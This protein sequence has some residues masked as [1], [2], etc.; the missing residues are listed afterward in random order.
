[1]FERNQYNSEVIINPPAMPVPLTSLVGREHAIGAVI[2]LLLRPE[3]RLVSLTGIGGV[4]KTRLAL[5]VATDISQ[6]FAHGVYF[7]PLAANRDPQT[8]LWEIAHS[9]GLYPNG[10]SSSVL[11]SLKTA[12]KAK[13]LLLVLDNLEQAGTT[14]PLLTELLTTCPELKI[15]ATSQAVLHLSGEYHFPVNPLAYPD[16]AK[17]P[18]LD[19]LRD[20]YPAIE[21]FLQRAEAITPLSMH[22]SEN[23]E[24]VARI[25]AALEGLPLAIE[26]AAARVKFLPPVALLS[27]LTNEPRLK[28]LT[29]G[30]Q[31]RP[32]RQQSLRATFEWSYALLSEDEQRI[33]RR[34]AVLARGCSLEA[35]ETVCLNSG[36]GETEEVNTPFLEVIASLIDKSLL[37]P[38]DLANQTPGVRLLETV[39]EF[40]LEKLSAA[41]ELENLQ[42]AHAAYYLALAEEAEPELHNFRQ[43][44]WRRQ[45]AQNEP[46]LEAALDYLLTAQDWEGL[47]R[48]AGALGW[49]WY[50]GGRLSE[51]LTFLKQA[52][53]QTASNAASHPAATARAL[54]AA[55][56]FALHLGRGEQAEAWLLQSLKLSK[57]LRDCQGVA[58]AAYALTLFHLI[59][60]SIAAAQAQ[61]ADLLSFVQ[62]SGDSWVQ[63]LAQ[64]TSGTIQ[65]YLGDFASAQIAY[66]LSAELYTEAGDLDLREL[67]LLL[68]CDATLAQQAEVQGQAGTSLENQLGKTANKNLSWSVGYLLLGYG[69]IA[70]R[71]GDWSRARFLLEQSLT[72]FEG[73][74]DQRGTAQVHGV[75]ARLALYRQDY[76]S[77]CAIAAECLQKA[78]N[79]DS[80]ETIIVC[81]EKLAD[82]A[83]EHN[84]LKWAVQLW[85]AG[86]RQR[87]LLDERQ[88]P[89][90]PAERKRLVEQAR[91]GLGAKAFEEEWISGYALTPE[92]ALNSHQNDNQSV[93]KN[94]TASSA[95]SSARKTRPA[96]LTRREF[97]VLQLLAE[98]LSNAEIAR[99]LVLTP[100][101]V[102]SYLNNVY[103]KLGVSS[104][105]AAMRYAIDHQLC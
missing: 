46:N 45:L 25:C 38:L 100:A 24:A 101:T 6:N 80:R 55:G 15:L 34:L 26:L 30:G 58:K 32:L 68:Q 8:V 28:V 20:N 62:T 12:L 61:V 82:I 98:G 89:V 47:L 11:D 74:G 2:A 44:W 52:L 54:F 93:L 19:T 16:P 18:P 4:G 40:A 1:M 23:I 105:T 29:Q 92:R 33:F 57:S 64:T 79:V 97:D 21:L 49:F 70:L 71:R 104:R 53:Y 84:R 35:A 76:R 73:A 85:A 102:I 5:K 9:L 96:G 41:S 48:L 27:Q 14:A 103:G 78:R 36:S 56:F 51:G 88:R 86:A 10:G 91:K 95:N 69:Q 43:A 67:M 65:M 60:G 22:N 39:R 66:S 50:L 77:A 87:Q 59:E 31:D 83:T 17:L 72:L 37:L 3:V 75:L 7:V 99:R 81:L 94:V 42:A 90:E 63:A 13:Q